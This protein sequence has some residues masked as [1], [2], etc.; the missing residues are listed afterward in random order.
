MFVENFQILL[1]EKMHVGGISF[2]KEI[3]V[4]TCLLWPLEYRNKKSN[5]KEIKLSAQLAILMALKLE[6]E[7]VV[8]ARR[9]RQ[10]KGGKKMHFIFHFT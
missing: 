5:L 10:S 7:K 8:R 4:W 2:C 9:A 3:G 6:L 1:G